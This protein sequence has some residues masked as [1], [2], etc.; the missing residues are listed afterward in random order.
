MVFFLPPN[1]DDKLPAIGDAWGKRVGRKTP[2]VFWI[3]ITMK[4]PGVK[5]V[6][7]LGK[8]PNYKLR[9]QIINNLRSAGFSIGKLGDRSDAKYTRVHTTWKRTPKASW[10]HISESEI[11]ELVAST[12][13][14]FS[15]K[16]DLLE[17][18]CLDCDW[19]MAGI[20]PE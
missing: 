12:W 2:L 16:L 4:N 5:I 19:S 10:E 9:Q 8:F 18:I 14:E 11:S 20:I 15:V 7:E 1:W 13:E 6:F 3:N 17:S